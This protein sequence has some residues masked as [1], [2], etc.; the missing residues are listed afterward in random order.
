MFIIWPLGP[1]KL[2]DFLGN[3]TGVRENIQFTVENGIFSL[4]TLV[5][6][7]N[8]MAHW[9]TRSIVKTLH[10]NLY[11]NTNLH[12]HSPS[13][14]Q[15]LLST[16][17]HKTKSLYIGDPLHSQNCQGGSRLF[18]KFL[19]PSCLLETTGTCACSPPPP[20]HH[21]HHHHHQVAGWL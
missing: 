3:L 18:K 17:V 21:H 8:L 10:T 6:I 19:H 4:L 11:L 15:S 7:I 12:H 5:S 14:I 2:I 9:A 13:N 16:L 1:G 20:H